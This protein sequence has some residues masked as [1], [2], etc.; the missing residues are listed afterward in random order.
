MNSEAI[1]YFGYFIEIKISICIFYYI[2]ILLTNL[3]LD[4]SNI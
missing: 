3:N 4:L 1:I 2:Q